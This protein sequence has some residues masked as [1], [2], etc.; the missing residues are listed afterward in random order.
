MTTPSP[1]RLSLFAE[2]W[3]RVASSMFPFI[4]LGICLIQYSHETPDSSS[5]WPW[6]SAFY[7]EFN[8]RIVDMLTCPLV[9]GIPLLLIVLFLAIP[10]R[11]MRWF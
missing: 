8:T 3:R 1:S 9:W 4:Y 5:V 10:Q 6:Q 7:T 11:A 2:C